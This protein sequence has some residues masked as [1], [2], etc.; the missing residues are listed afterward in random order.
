MAA[1]ITNASKRIKPNNIV[2]AIG[3]LTLFA[4]VFYSNFINLFSLQ[5][6]YFI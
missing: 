4:F 6:L 2:F 1:N 3:I 5:I